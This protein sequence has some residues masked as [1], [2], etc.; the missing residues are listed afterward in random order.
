MTQSRI[1]FENEGEIDIRALKT[2]GVS[3]KEG[4]NPIGEF[5]TGFKYAIGILLRNQQSIEVFVGEKVYNVSS[6]PQTIR[7]ED[8]SIV[9]LNGEELGFTTNIGKNWELWMAYRELYCNTVDEGGSSREVSPSDIIL[10]EAGKTKVIITGDKFAEEHR[11]RAT[12]ILS[13]QATQVIKDVGE[14]HHVSSKSFFYRGIRVYKT[15]EPFLYTYNRTSKM[16]LT[17]D[18]T[19][20]YEYELRSIVA[21][22]ICCSEDETFLK[23]VLTA[24]QDFYENQ[25]DVDWPSAK[26][27][28]DAFFKVVG[29]L[30]KDN[31]S[32]LNRTAMRMYQGKYPE[33]DII[34]DMPLSIVEQKQLKRAIEFCALIGYQ[35]DSRQIV[36]VKSLGENCLGLAK[37]GKI[38]IS[39]QA[40]SLGTKMVAATLME[41]FIHLD[42][43]LDDCTREMQ[44][45]LF[46]KIVSMGEEINQEPL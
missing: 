2:F 15:G 44:N 37:D 14:I 11:G 26:P 30:M 40:F 5:G 6:T 41:E 36:A 12:F 7:G 25:M 46:H 18:R 31:I 19:V 13:S 42:R 32:N 43:L 27:V 8:F 45:Y 24:P 38:Y 10:P 39:Q 35:V 29:E 28:S 33:K 22:L 17:E 23:D 3:V 16:S 9:T 21:K 4:D 1:L 20:R 34:E